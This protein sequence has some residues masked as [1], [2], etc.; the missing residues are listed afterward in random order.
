M[1]SRIE[2][3]VYQNTIRF[4]DQDVLVVINSLYATMHST[5]KYN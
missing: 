1:I 3:F 2:Y 4:V 5:G